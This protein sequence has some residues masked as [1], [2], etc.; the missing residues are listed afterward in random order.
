MFSCLKCKYI[1]DKICKESLL[2]KNLSEHHLARFEEILKNGIEVYTP[3]FGKYDYHKYVYLINNSLIIEYIYSKFHRK[4]LE[5][6]EIN[7]ANIIKFDFKD[8]ELT[9]QFVLENEELFDT[10]VLKCY[11]NS[12]RARL[13]FHKIFNDWLDNKKQQLIND[14][15][16]ESDIDEKVEEKSNK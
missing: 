13:F 15:N 1:K 10:E 16:I 5:N 3:N 9:G 12:Y 11:F 7:I 2:E 6:K 14:D 8:N 4:Y